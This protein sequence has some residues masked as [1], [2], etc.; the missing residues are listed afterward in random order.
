MTQLLWAQKAQERAAARALKEQREREN[1][2]RARL[3]E[4]ELA[5]RRLTTERREDLRFRIRGCCEV[6]PCNA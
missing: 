4:E 6:H 1:E 2:E 3:E 5:N